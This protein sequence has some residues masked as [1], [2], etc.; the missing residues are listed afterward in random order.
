MSFVAFVEFH[1]AA[2]RREEAWAIFGPMLGQTRA[3]EGAQRIDW[4][5]DRADDC[6]WTLYE[7]W[8]SP[9]A[10]AAY[11]AYRMGEGAVPA[12]ATVLDRPPVL[13]RFDAGPSN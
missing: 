7:E 8:A 2:D 9:E 4:L 11:R 13:R 5:I 12:L 1:V 3:F 10:E 6:A